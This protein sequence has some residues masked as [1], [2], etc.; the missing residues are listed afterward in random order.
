MLLRFISFLS[1]WLA[2]RPRPKAKGASRQGSML[3]PLEDRIAPATF[4]NTHI[5]TYTDVDGDHVTVKSSN[6]L[7]TKS[8]AN[9]ILTFSTGSV[10]GASTPQQLQEINL[11]S[12]GSNIVAGDS[13]SV[14]VQQA[15]GGNGLANVGFIDSNFALGHVLIQGDL[16]RI[17][18]G[19]NTPGNAHYV[20]LAS[21]TVNSLG[22]EGISTQAAGGDLV[23]TIFG[24]LGSIT[25]QKDMVDAQ[26]N[27]TSNTASTVVNGFINSVK[28][29]GS[30]MGGSDSLGGSFTTDGNINSVVIGGDMVGGSGANSASFQVGGKIGSF[31][32]GSLV[33]YTVA[34]DTT[35]QG[36][37]SASIV[38]GNS[39][40]STG[41][42]G[43]LTI[44]G[45]L[46][47][48]DGSGSAEVSMASST[49]GSFGAVKIG[50]A[51]TGGSGANSGE[52]AA[53]SF[54]AISIAK[55]I[56]G[57]SGLDSGSITSTNGITSLTI[58]QGGIVGG[59]DTDSGAV[60]AAIAPTNSAVIG[61]VVIYGDITGSSASGIS[62]IAGTGQINTSSSIMSLTLHGSLA[63]A[64]ATTS[65]SVIATGSIGHVSIFA[66]GTSTGSILGGAGSD[67]GELNAASI[68]SVSMAGQVKGS[69]G[70]NSG[71]IV[72]TGDIGS[73]TLGGGITGGGGT[74]SGVVTTGTGFG[75]NLG[76]LTLTGGGITG[77]AG[78][79]SGQVAIGGKIGS[80]KLNGA[81]ITGA[82]GA[83]SGAIIATDSIGSISI[84]SLISVASEGAGAGEISTGGSLASLIFTGAGSAPAVDSG[85]V[86][87]TGSAGS[88][89]VHGSVTGSVAST[90]EFLIGGA[91]K[92]FSISGA[93]NGGAGNDSGS[94]FAGLDDAGV[95]GSLTISG[96]V[97]GGG[98]NGS[99]EVFG[100]GGIT[101][102]TLGDL[103][104][105]GGQA[106][107]S[108]VSDY[109]LGAVS[110]TGTG[111][112]VTTH[113]VIGGGGANSG[114]ISAGATIGSVTIHG[115]LQGAGGAGSGS[116]VSHSRFTASGDV[117]GD[118]G[119]ISI[120]GSISGGM[121]ANSGQI[122]AAGNL[123][124]VSVTGNVTGGLAS[125]TGGVV[126]G[127]D[128]TGLAGGDITTL[129]IGGALRGADVPAGGYDIAGSG[130]VE[131]GHI[132]AIT[133]GSI[134]AGTVG[135]ATTVKGDGAILAA[136]DIASLT[137]T[138]SITGNYVN[139]VVI[140]AVGQVN[141]GKTD[142]ALGRISVDGAVTF[143]N[144]L[145]GYDQTGAPV[146]G[147]A[148]IGAVTV[149]GN[150]SGS[151]LVAGVIAGTDGHFGALNATLIT[152]SA[153]VIPTIASIIIKGQVVSATLPLG[154][155]DVK[156]TY[157][158]VAKEID[159]LSVHG[160]AQSL[161]NG[162]I[163]PVGD[164][165]DTVL[166]DV[167]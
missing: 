50:G 23:S 130:Y 2:P 70:S 15:G 102:A 63:G 140:S 151:N 32:V 85:Q 56:I 41:G 156:D 89:T 111:T 9:N 18:A 4:V 100:G 101:H 139:P 90:G 110:V 91:V 97:I 55:G 8:N 80:V 114:Q 117:Q 157:G 13:I 121:G 86:D 61:K 14:T 136:N 62:S 29:G 81:A 5:V 162:V 68:G 106:S 148:G 31:T 126:A 160:V 33:G 27:V 10:D 147:A 116:I 71:Q 112:G 35:G 88:I 125:G 152:S 36:Q 21:L 76:S 6:P 129:K 49:S 26:V 165:I 11:T 69:T 51:I 65:G 24:E 7:F 99:G 30:L 34:G 154:D 167:S 95:I 166:R 87:V 142:L 122:S 107:G 20:G 19:T 93:L 134:Q 84:G 135:A 78:M 22:A 16:G 105:G 44:N 60:I 133:V 25:V 77:G 12:L 96:G 155:T 39:F 132:G 73:V 42:I 123:K 161:K 67:S 48:G 79:D 38:T 64:A 3:E 98:G 113:G 57:A 115:A 54:G 28:I 45:N 74:G 120:T 52:L 146:N 37:G 159:A 103:I 109:A 119:S 124:T 108:I 92:S 1:S 72:A 158:F 59:T 83:S 145:A 58:L 164:S 104:G 143:A 40:P 118:I 150:W 53:N 137:V 128:L 82:A 17:E 138:G 163:D 94:I 149:G 66:N 144:F 127:A 47:G 141:P 131:A 46:Q 153:S 43:S 75:D